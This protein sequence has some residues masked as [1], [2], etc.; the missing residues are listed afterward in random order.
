MVQLLF[1]RSALSHPFGGGTVD[2]VG[3]DANHTI[4]SHGQTSRRY[5]LLQ[6]KQAR[7]YPPGV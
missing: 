1:G 6:G 5:I 3:G 2:E 4:I 7:T